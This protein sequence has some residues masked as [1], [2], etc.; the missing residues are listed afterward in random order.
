M[1][2]FMILVQ[3]NGLYWDVAGFC[4]HY[5][6][7]IILIFIA[8]VLLDLSLIVNSN[9]FKLSI[10]NEVG[11][12]LVEKCIDFERNSCHVS[13]CVRSSFFEKFVSLFFKL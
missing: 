6:Y 5:L 13:N 10:F 11:L 12:G 2:S 3:K 8:Y 9:S 7:F 4:E 1:L